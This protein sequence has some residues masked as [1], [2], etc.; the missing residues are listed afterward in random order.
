MQKHWITGEAWTLTFST[1]LKR[2]KIQSVLRGFYLVDCDGY[3]RF[4]SLRP[5][6]NQNYS[7]AIHPII[8]L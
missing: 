3:D 7:A 5:T 1:T 8:A 2:S 4:S 6:G